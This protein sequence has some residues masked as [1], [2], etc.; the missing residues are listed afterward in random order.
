MLRGEAPCESGG[1]SLGSSRM[2]TLMTPSLRPLRS[3]LARM[4]FLAFVA[5]PAFAFQGS[6]SCVTAQAIAG[7]GVFNFDCTAATTGPQGQNEALCYFFGASTIDHDV[8]FEWTADCTG[9][10]AVKTCPFTSEDT[11]IAAYPGG[12]CPIAG[13]NNALACNDD[14]CGVNGF[15]SE[16][17]FACVNGTSYMIQIGYFPGAPATV[18]GQFQIYYS[19]CGGGGGGGP[20]YRLAFSMNYKGPYHGEQD[21]N[22]NLMRESDMCLPAGGDPELG[23][24]AGAEI[25]IDGSDLALPQ[26][27][28][29]S[30]PQPGVPC[31][32][33]VD[34]LSRGQDHILQASG[35]TT[36]GHIFFSVDE[37]A[38]GIP[39]NPHRPSVTSEGAFG[40]E[41]ASAD[42]FKLVNGMLPGPI[43]PPNFKGPWGNLAIVDG[44]GKRSASGF[45]YPGVGL[46]E[47]NPPNAG[48]INAGSNSDS[49]NLYQEDVHGDPGEVSPSNPAFFSL[50]GDI[51]D[52]EENVPGSGSAF[53]NGL[54]NPGDILMSM[55]PGTQLQIYAQSQQLGLDLDNEQLYDDDLDALILWENGNG[56]F[57]PA[58]APYQWLSGDVDMLLFSVRRDSPIIGRLDSIWGIP[59]CE[60]DL[61]IPPVSA[62]V[63]VVGPSTPGI[64]VAAEA[65]GLRAGRDGKSGSDD[66]N[67]ADTGG[68][69]FFDCNNNGTE[70]AEDISYGTSDDMNSNGIPDECEDFV[71]YCSGNEFA[72]ALVGNQCPCGNCDTTSTDLVGC[73]NGTGVGGRLR[74]SGSTSVA[75]PSTEWFTLEG[76]GLVPNKPGL[77]F[78][79]NNP[80]PGITSPTPGV[81]VM[82]GDGLRCAGGSVV[83]LQ[84]KSASSSGE[85]NTTADLIT[86]GVISAGDTKYFQ[87]WYRDPASSPCG[88]TFNL[89]NGLQVNFD[90]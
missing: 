78:Q 62:G 47:P 39:F 1:L 51:P 44:D 74:G 80:I 90:A 10:A 42:L 16:I 40:A 57:E 73:A 60:G 31:G 46:K 68:D 12:G 53:L 37:R 83:R 55:G 79:G 81:G 50:D 61:L 48:P 84:V 32:V 67:G 5:G 6:D 23:G 29:C 52:S 27:A 2:F 88:S 9:T 22:G 18:P 54:F 43:P 4:L 24:H 70:D 85:S 64:F 8:W 26:W 72:S 14:L 69:P 63:G 75:A 45:Q 17:A 89:T 82:F 66:L 56:I 15:Q 38:R 49:M 20:A 58:S 19:S 86:E 35:A 59:I 7:P 25:L 71:E 28:L 3:G 13:Q 41:E 21:N 36:S 87:L 76:S 34:A 65:M 33:E 77:Y 30:N 11:K